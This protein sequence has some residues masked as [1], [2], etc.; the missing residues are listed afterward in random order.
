MVSVVSAITTNVSQLTRA[1]PI[2]NNSAMVCPCNV[3]RRASIANNNGRSERSTSLLF[4]FFT[5]HD[6][7]YNTTARIP[8]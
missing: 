4:V 1:S 8:T 6:A 7:P 5:S 2:A 3:I